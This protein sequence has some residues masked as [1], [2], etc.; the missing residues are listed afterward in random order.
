MHAS[1]PR[2]RERDRPDGECVCVKGKNL[3]GNK[4]VEP[5]ATSVLLLPCIKNVE[6]VGG[7]RGKV[8]LG[9]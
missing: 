4:T 1:L 3:T 6:E 5:A 7:P 2:G 9:H 8:E